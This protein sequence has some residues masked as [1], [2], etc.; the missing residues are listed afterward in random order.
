MARAYLPVCGI[1][2]E[3]VGRRQHHDRIGW[4]PCEDAVNQNGVTRYDASYGIVL[5][6]LAHGF[7]GNLFG[8]KRIAMH[9]AESRRV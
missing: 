3:R 1:A 2:P 9:V 5:D 7:V 6:N 8:K 4:L